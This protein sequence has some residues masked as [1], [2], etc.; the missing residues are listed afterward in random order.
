MIGAL[1]L[2]AALSGAPGAAA[3]PY[4]PAV[5]VE[6]SRG[7]W[8]RP[9][10]PRPDGCPA[11]M[12]WRTDGARVRAVLRFRKPGG[13]FTTDLRRSECRGEWSTTRPKGEASGP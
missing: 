7:V 8:M 5:A 9:V 6:V 12:P 3:A 13:G 2:V 11:F 1:S 4:P 10:A